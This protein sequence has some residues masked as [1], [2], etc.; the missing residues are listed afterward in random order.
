MIE[1]VSTWNKSITSL[2]TQKDNIFH[3]LQDIAEEYEIPRYCSIEM[4]TVELTRKNVPSFKWFSLVEEYYRIDG[5]FN[6][7]RDFLVITDN[8]NL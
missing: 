4:I 1:R 2:Q 5:E 7:L 6:A 3:T 8:F